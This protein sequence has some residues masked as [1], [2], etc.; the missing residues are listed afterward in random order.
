[1]VRFHDIA[2][3]HRSKHED[4]IS[5]GTFWQCIR[6]IVYLNEY[7][8]FFLFLTKTPCSEMVNFTL[9]PVQGSEIILF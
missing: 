5:V 3:T 9:V 8:F 1:M 4:F 6:L 7:K 2:V